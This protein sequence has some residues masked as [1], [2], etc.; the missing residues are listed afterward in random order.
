MQSSGQTSQYHL[1]IKSIK[2]G[3]K[4]MFE[5]RLKTEMFSMIIT[6]GEKGA[7]LSSFIGEDRIRDGSLRFISKKEITES[8]EKFAGLTINYLWDTKDP[9]D[10]VMTAKVLLQ[11]A[12]TPDGD[13]FICYIA[14]EGDP[15]IEYTGEIR[16]I[17]EPQ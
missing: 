6:T 13:R 3:G 1:L 11:V 2:V 9:N 4:P 10:R 5:E 7:V 17:T 12:Y 8:Q 16:N 15:I 14:E